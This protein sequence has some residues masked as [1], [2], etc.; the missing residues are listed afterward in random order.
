MLHIA[1]PHLSWAKYIFQRLNVFERASRAGMTKKD[2]R[3]A[4]KPLAGDSSRGTYEG[5]HVFPG[6]HVSRK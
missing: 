4:V 3:A 6:R 2:C 1:G 5:S